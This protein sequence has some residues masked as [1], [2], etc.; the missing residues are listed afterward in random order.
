MK[1]K[2]TMSFLLALA[3][4]LSAVCIVSLSSCKKAGKTGESKTITVKVID[5]EGKETVFTIKTDEN[6]LRGALEQEKLIEGTEGP[7]GLY[8]TTVNGLSADWDRDG[9]Y[10]QFT[11]SGEYLM[12][13]VDETGIADGDVFELTYTKG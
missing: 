1:A 7:Y 3:V 4:I 5:N 8:V 12:T 10:W 2:K 6:Y 13:G 9:T 11:K